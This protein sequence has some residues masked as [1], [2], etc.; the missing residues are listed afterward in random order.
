MKLRACQKLL[1]ILLTSLLCGCIQEMLNQCSDDLAILKELECQTNS[2]DENRD[3]TDDNESEQ[4][5]VSQEMLFDGGVGEEQV[6][7]TSPNDLDLCLELETGQQRAS[8]AGLV[9]SF[10]VDYLFVFV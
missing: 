5:V 4:I 1:T 9:V 8:I 3:P 7:M 2:S 6:K 10:V